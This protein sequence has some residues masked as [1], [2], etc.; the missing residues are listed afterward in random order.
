MQELSETC[1]T[2]RD[3]EEGREEGERG[4]DL[5]SLKPREKSVGEAIDMD[6]V[7]QP[8]DLEWFF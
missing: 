5:A 4:T 3:E 2:L 6:K 7:E 8:T 1:D